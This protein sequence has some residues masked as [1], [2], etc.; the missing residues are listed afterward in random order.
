VPLLLLVIALTLGLGVV[1][2][3]A[4]ED[5][6]PDC[7]FTEF[8]EEGEPVGPEFCTT[9]VWFKQAETLAGNLGATDAHAYPSW[10][11]EPPS[12]S[13]SAGAGAGFLTIGP[14]RQMASNPDTDPYFGATF[15]GSYTG[16]IDNLVIEMYMFAPATAASDTGNY[17]GSIEL[18][19][20]GTLVLWPT[21]VD[22]P[23]EEGGDAALKTTFAI[24]N[25]H[26]AMQM[27][28]LETGE[29][30]EH[31][32]RF[33]LSGYGLASGTAIVVFDT[34]EVPSGMVFNT[35]ELGDIPAF[36]A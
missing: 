29:G 14:P 31:E 34:T 7:Y 36:P 24:T 23:T 8:D 12:A 5:G 4:A 21:Q 10:D 1:P 30:V 3:I 26:D 35:P 2:A 20:D 22:L 28:G 15:E 27:E 18:G 32:V 19:I 17:V 6:E 16:N 33:F 13:V 11:T 9:E 25:I